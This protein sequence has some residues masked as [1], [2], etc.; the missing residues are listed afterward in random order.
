M[1]KYQNFLKR[2]GMNE[3]EIQVYLTLLE[4]PHILVTEIAKKT[5]LHRPMVYK[6]LK[7][8]EDE[9][10]VEKS[11]SEKRYFYHTT[12]P[13]ELRNK[14]IELDQM[15]DRI[16]PEL[17]EIHQRNHESP[18]LSIREG[19]EG[20]QSIHQDLVN[21]LPKNGI[22]YRYSSSRREFADRSLYVSDN[23]HEKQK[24][25]ELERYVITS[26]DRKPYR[27]GNPYREVVSIPK[28]FD[29][30]DDNITKLIYG[31]RVSIID[32]DTQV[33]W[34]IESE[35]FARYEEKIFKL[36]FKSLKN[37]E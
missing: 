3:V 9:G 30:F 15:A 25:K 31:N 8:L 33:A 16:I 12:G 23:Y 19:I 20:I 4:H 34:T 21:L 11:Q 13:E 35:R 18:I 2:L 17:T 5:N 29:A 22:Y 37:M 24:S 10:F 27:E 6:V 26:E 32:Y 36:L 28:G 7:S 14:L 1:K